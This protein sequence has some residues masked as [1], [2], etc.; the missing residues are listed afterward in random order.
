MRK[1]SH[2]IKTYFP[3]KPKPQLKW[4]F[5]NDKGEAD[6]DQPD[7]SNEAT[8]TEDNVSLSVDQVRSYF[9]LNF[10][11]IYDAYHQHLLYHQDLCE[12][13]L[14]HIEL[15]KDTKFWEFFLNTTTRQSNRVLMFNLLWT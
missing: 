11:K 12:K 5:E 4:I 14:D 9:L 13:Q 15:R 3:G 6:A 2:L 8:K 7:L 1:I 10:P